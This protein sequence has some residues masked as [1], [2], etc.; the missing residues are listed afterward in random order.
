MGGNMNEF[1]QLMTNKLTSRNKN[2]KTIQSV[3][4]KAKKKLS[5]CIVIFY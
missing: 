1:E 2:V 4:N 5:P 3:C